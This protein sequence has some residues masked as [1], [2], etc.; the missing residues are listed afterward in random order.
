LLE[1]DKTE[2]KKKRRN[3]KQLGKKGKKEVE[4]QREKKLKETSLELYEGMK[5]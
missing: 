4:T 5:K 1:I 2:R 3:I